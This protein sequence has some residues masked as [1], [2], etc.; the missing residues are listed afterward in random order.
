MNEVIIG[1]TTNAS[2]QAGPKQVP[3]LMFLCT[4]NIHMIV[5][6]ALLLLVHGTIVKFSS[7]E[8]DI[9]HVF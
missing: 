9:P 1:T 6:L 5:H 3:N 4:A 7:A 2:Q 8:I